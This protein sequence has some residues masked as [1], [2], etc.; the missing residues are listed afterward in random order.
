MRSDE[1]ELWNRIKA[2]QFDKPGIK[3]TF[4]KR[5]AKENGFSESFAGQVVEEYRKFIFL[6]CVSKQQISPS[7]NVDLAWHLHLTYTRSYWTDLCENTIKRDLH[8]DPT[9]GGSEEDRKFK[10]LYHD[11][12][13]L[14]R[15]YF[16]FD[17]PESV[18]P[19]DIGSK[20]GPDKAN[21]YD[22]FFGFLRNRRR[23]SMTVILVM[24]AGLLVGCSAI[25]DSFPIILSLALVAGIGVF[26]LVR[27]KKRS[28]GE[29]GSGCSS[30]GCGGTTS[31]FG[32]DDN[33]GSDGGGDSGCSSGCSGGCGGG[34]D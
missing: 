11:T 6:C 12:L 34:G 21:V 18:W 3:L 17:A 7:P 20:G 14:Y 19:N 9:E 16:S 25:T 8:H 2:F 23:F 4:A 15:T 30:S 33:G 27:R 31:I 13:E 1:L 32:G 24:L 26:A 28:N 5:L 22:S 29:G 10:G